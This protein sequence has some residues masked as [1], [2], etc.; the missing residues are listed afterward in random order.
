MN[1]SLQEVFLRVVLLLPP[2]A[3]SCLNTGA[4]RQQNQDDQL[5]HLLSVTMCILL[6]IFEGPYEV[7]GNYLVCR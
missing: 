7:G 2:A 6:L 1:V 3:L 4:S 5:E